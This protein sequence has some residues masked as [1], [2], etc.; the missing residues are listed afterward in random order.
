M[1]SR[2]ENFGRRA[3]MIAFTCTAVSSPGLRDEE[4]EAK[5]REVSVRSL[6]ELEY[7]RAHNNIAGR[8]PVPGK[9]HASSA[10]ATWRDLGAWRV[11]IG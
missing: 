11:V 6:Q 1:D 3:L 9:T 5:S 2:N 7:K 8:Q 4:D 10:I